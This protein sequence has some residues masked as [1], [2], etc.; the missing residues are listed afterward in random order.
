[1]LDARARATQAYTEYVEE[2]AVSA[3]PQMGVDPAFGA[4]T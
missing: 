2:P 4:K 1:M 3:T